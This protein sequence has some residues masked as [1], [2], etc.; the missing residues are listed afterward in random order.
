MITRI[1]AS[2]FTIFLS[3]VV[4][5]DH[6]SADYTAAVYEHVV[7]SAVRHDVSQKLAM[8]IMNE[9]IDVYEKQIA[10]ASAEVIII[11]TH[12]NVINL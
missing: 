7:R 9:N 2:S 6:S 11:N 3:L 12:R 10:I 5:I 1:S 8:K 4:F